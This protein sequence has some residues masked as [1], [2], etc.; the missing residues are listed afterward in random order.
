VEASHAE[1]A[2]PGQ[3]AFAATS[4]E[5]AQLLA[6]IEGIDLREGLETQGRRLARRHVLIPVR[7]LLLR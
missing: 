6:R 2:Q 3:P 1:A 5:A 7:G 4:G